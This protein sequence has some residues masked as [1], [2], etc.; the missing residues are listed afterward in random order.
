MQ[1][2]MI[3]QAWRVFQREGWEAARNIDSQQYAHAQASSV[4]LTKA[5]SIHSSLRQPDK[6]HRHQ[7]VTQHEQ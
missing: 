7:Y 6:Y 4:R 2:Y 5:T 1:V 3:M